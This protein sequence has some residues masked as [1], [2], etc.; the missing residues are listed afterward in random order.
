MIPNNPPTP[1]TDV[2]TVSFVESGVPLYYQL[3]TVLR[4]SIIS[5]RF[6]IGGK[7]P[8]EAELVEQYGVSRATVR[9]A[10]QHLREEGLIR[11]E[12]GRGTF[13]A[14]T[15]EFTGNLEMDGTLNGLIAMGLAT[16]PR[17]IELREVTL[18]PQE[19]AALGMEPGA[20]VLRVYRVRYYKEH[21]YCYII[22]TLPLEIGRGISAA[23]WERGSMLRYLQKNHGI[24]LGDA[25]EH[26]R[27][28]VADSNLA[29]WL[30][31][32][33]GA[34]LLQVNYL[35]RDANGD[36]VETPVI[37]YRSDMHAFTLRLTWSEE[38]PDGT[39]RWSLR[40]EPEA[41]EDDLG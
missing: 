4:E 26:V 27:A 36:P 31:V 35:I 40:D 24:R 10:L 33:I 15:P 23:E 18:P 5:G 2:S 6:P 21:P 19:A 29:R 32:R 1:D 13:V 20:P 8:T 30:E 11:R 25:D 22:N 3:A 34:P 16:S 17:L 28:T 37:Y 39:T 41:H 9:G 38:S 7:I 12:A 14:R